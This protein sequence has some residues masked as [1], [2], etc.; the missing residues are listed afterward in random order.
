MDDAS[1]FLDL[2]TDIELQVGVRLDLLN[3]YPHLLTFFRVL[4]PTLI[5]IPT[6]KPPTVIDV[7]P[8]IP[9]A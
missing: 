8:T 2:K 7:A 3:Y 6:A 1:E 4:V 9:K 5:D